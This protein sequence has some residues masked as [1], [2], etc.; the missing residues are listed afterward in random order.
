MKMK[1]L[2]NYN[3]LCTLDTFYETVFGVGTIRCKIFELK[4]CPERTRVLKICINYMSNYEH[5]FA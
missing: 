5:F 4:E 1:P 3:L 2:T